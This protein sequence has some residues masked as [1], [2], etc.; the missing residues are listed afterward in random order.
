MGPC[1]SCCRG[2]GGVNC[3][4]DLIVKWTCQFRGRGINHT[5]NLRGK[6]DLAI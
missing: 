4:D 5:D 1:C 2:R 6:S 3:T